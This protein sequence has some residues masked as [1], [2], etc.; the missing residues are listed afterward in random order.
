M[1][2][3]NCV[4]INIVVLEIIKKLAA[5]YKKD[6]PDWEEKLYGKKTKKVETAKKEIK[7]NK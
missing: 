1:P 2:A 3:K 7:D 4:E 6:N 5:M